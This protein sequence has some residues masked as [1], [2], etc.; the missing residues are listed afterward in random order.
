MPHRLLIV[1]SP[2][3]AK[4]IASFLK[5][6]ATVLSSFGHVRDLPKSETGVDVAHDFE[7]TY[8]IPTKA[9]PHVAEL[10][11]AAKKADEI[12]LATD[13]DRE[14]E[15]IAWHIAEVLG[16]LKKPMKRVTFHEIT[17][18]AILHALE[19]PRDIDE[20]LV[21]AQQARR[22]LDRLVGYEL[23]PLLWEKVR[24]G[25]SAGRVQS[26]AVRLVVERERERN[27]F[28]VESFWSVEALVEKD[29][30]VFPALLNSVDGKK[31]EKMDIK[32]EGEAQ[33]IVDAL[34]GESLKVTALET[35]SVTKNPLPPFTTSTL[36]IEANQR[37]GWSAKATMRNAQR[38]YET[39]RITYMRTD[40]VNLSQKFLQETQA[41]LLTAFGKTYAQGSRTFATKSKGAQEAHEAIRPT[42]VT[43]H[44]ETLHG[45]LEG[46][47]AKL[48]DLIWRRAVASQMPAAKM[49]RT[50]VDL[51]AKHYGFRANGSR[52]EFDGFMRVYR[53]AKEQILPPLKEGELLPVQKLEALGHQTEPP[54]RYSD[55]TLVKALEA[56]GIGRPST[57]APTIETV[58]TRGYVE[59]E[60]KNKRLFP[61]DT[62]LIV[63]DVLVEH[64]PSIVDLEFTA[65]MEKKLDDVA[66]GKEAWVPMLREFYLPFHT[67]IETKSKALTRKDI[68]KERVLGKDPETGMDVVVRTGRFG[69]YVERAGRTEEEEPRRG[70]LLKGMSMETI[71]LEDA[72]SLL[73]IPY[74]VTGVGTYGTVTVATGRFG[75]Y[76]K[77]GDIN[78]SLP[79]EVD[80][81]FLTA[82]L[83]LPILEAGIARKKSFQEPMAKL[84][85]DPTS[86]GELLVKNGRFGPYVTDG[87]TNATV[88]KRLDPATLTRE[89]AIDLL[90]KKRARPPGRGRFAK[91]TVEAPK[92]TAAKKKT[93]RSQKNQES[94]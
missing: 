21:N 52:I 49:L 70:S 1:E 66:E 17:K 57:Y 59:R 19:H 8:V 15:A 77:A 54:A 30:T 7:P 5:N 14:G 37:Y 4:T 75:P 61:T 86:H 27:A 41:H 31:L 85:E 79:Q 39:G 32:N 36:Q 50:G 34:R 12:L 2:T 64:F 26:V 89:D 76:V 69:P 55:A 46:S 82:D 3:K 33:Q 84:G 28:V 72:R 81:R 78:I 23:S 24:R 18:S 48:Y 35:S 73:R 93:R 43:L 47:E 53:A 74:E 87:I 67:T 65:S 92:K 20:H 29:G 94:A 44:P 40:S 13:E 71:T 42:E 63:N 25:L 10:K 11:A 58:I 91:K 51:S 68:L 38:L 6:E 9:K 16:S 60:E 80:P 22:I 62:G 88:P 56:H 83:I 90:V 45:V